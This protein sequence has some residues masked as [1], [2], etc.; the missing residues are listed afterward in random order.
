M[1]VCVI[2]KDSQQKRCLGFP[3]PQMLARDIHA[4]FFLASNLGLFLLVSEA[5][6]GKHTHTHRA[7]QKGYKL[8]T[9]AITLWPPGLVGLLANSTSTHTQLT[10]CCPLYHP[11]YRTV[12]SLSEILK[13]LAQVHI[14]CGQSWKQASLMVKNRAPQIK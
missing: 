1:R 2:L 5:Y 12:D 6:S 8:C 13:P 7:I 10:D 4:V 3:Q 14:L 11:R 9:V